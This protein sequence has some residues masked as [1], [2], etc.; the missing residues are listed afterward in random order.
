MHATSLIKLAFYFAT[1]KTPTRISK[2][3]AVGP[4]LRLTAVS[5][6]SQTNTL[7]CLEKRA[8]VAFGWWPITEIGVQ[9]ILVPLKRL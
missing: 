4:H 8:K 6:R 1:T 9:D 7:R 5:Q 2:T 3:A